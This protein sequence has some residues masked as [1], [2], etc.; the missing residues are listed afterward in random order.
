MALANFWRV[1]EWRSQA[2][3]VDTSYPVLQEHSNVCPQ[4]P[5]TSTD[6]LFVYNDFIS[7]NTYCL[8][9]VLIFLGL[10]G[11]LGP[12]SLLCQSTSWGWFLFFQILIIIAPEMSAGSSLSYYAPFPWE[13]KEY[14]FKSENLFSLCI[15]S[16]CSKLFKVRGCLSVLVIPNTQDEREPNWSPPTNNMY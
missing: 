9:F 14:D 10:F 12:G 4:P 8:L 15:S 5:V 13:F 2:D 6:I 11:F 7:V 16:R 3:G 1:G